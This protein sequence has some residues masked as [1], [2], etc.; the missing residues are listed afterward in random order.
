MKGKK[1]LIIDDE[2]DFG[3]LMTDFFTK[4]GYQVFVAPSIAKGMEILKSENPDFIFLDNN[5]P[6]GCGWSETE[7]IL[8]NYP[9]TRLN[10]ISALD[11]PKTSASSFQ[12]MYK[13]F[14]KDELNKIFH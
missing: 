5:L 2:E 1:V 8:M 14:I 10:L 9:N 11:V 3:F 13:P 4:K 6:D 12:I 7:F